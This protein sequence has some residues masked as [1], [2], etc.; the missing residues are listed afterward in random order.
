[1]RYFEEIRCN[2]C[3]NS[4][5]R[6]VY[7]VK[8][9]YWSKYPIT[10]LSDYLFSIVKCINCGLIYVTPRIKEKYLKEIYEKWLVGEDDFREK[11]L[12]PW[13]NLFLIR[14]F[15]SLERICHKGDLLDIGC[16]WGHLL[17]YSSSL[18]WNGKGCEID[19]IKYQFCKDQNLN[20]VNAGLN[21]I[22]VMEE[23]YDLITAIQ[24]ME[25]LPDPMATIKRVHQLL[26][27]GGIF[28]IDVPNFYS[29]SSIRHRKKW[30]IIHPVEHL[31]YYTYPILKKMLT[32]NSFKVIKKKLPVN[33]FSKKRKELEKIMVFLEDTFGLYLDNITIFARKETYK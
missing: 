11:D 29:A 28:V 4:H 22:D 14:L 23:S 8:E 10:E 27:P 15:T 17:R 6:L 20:V 32:Q 3:K 2:Y 33:Q 13:S 18:G 25:H 30:H 12:D 5:G 7:K 1:M 24:V 19:K 21:E 9:S 16:G 31:Y 26:K